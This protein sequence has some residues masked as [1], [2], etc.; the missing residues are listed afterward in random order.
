MK[1]LL[2]ALCLMLG[3]VGC[4]SYGSG[5]MNLTAAPAPMFAPAAGTYSVPQLT[6]AIG[7]TQQ[8]AT[9]YFT[10]DG[11]TPSLNSQVYAGPFAISRTTKVRA[12]AA[13]NG[14]STSPVATADY[15]LQ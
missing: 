2:L 5:G 11:T 1:S 9:I 10:T 8:A 13:A 6:I 12:I 7:D 14:F 15:T 3:L 4:G